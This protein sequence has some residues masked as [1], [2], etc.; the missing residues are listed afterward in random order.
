M[1]R[2]KF[3]NLIFVA[4]LGKKFVFSPPIYRNFSTGKSIQ[5]YRYS[6]KMNFTGGE[7]MEK[8]AQRLGEKAAENFDK[9]MRD[10]LNG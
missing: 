3:F 10:I 9:R 7:E 1:N 2:R 5:W 8:A 4:I 6:N